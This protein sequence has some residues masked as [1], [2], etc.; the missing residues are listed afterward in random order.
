MLKQGV[1]FGSFGVVLGITVGYLFW[2]IASLKEPASLP[3]APAPV[4]PATTDH[5]VAAAQP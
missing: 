5:D 3:H 4:S 2:G 1:G